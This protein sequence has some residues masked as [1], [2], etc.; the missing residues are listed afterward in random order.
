MFSTKIL[1]KILIILFLRNLNLF[2]IKFT[3][4][5]WPSILRLACSFKFK[6]NASHIHRIR[7]IRHCF[8]TKSKYKKA[9]IWEGK[10]NDSAVVRRCLDTTFPLH[11]YWYTNFIYNINLPF[12]WVLYTSILL[13]FY[14][15]LFNLFYQQLKLDMPIPYIK[16][17]FCIFQID[18]FIC[19]F[20]FSF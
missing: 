5:L 16:L 12:I 3:N 19:L 18:G 14:R 9:I 8:D 11:V 15:L 6:Y 2:F 13:M 1:L 20:L 7:K 17:I 10:L 4:Y